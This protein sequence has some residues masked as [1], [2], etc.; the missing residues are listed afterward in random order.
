LWPQRI[1][2][3]AIPQVGEV[4][5]TGATRGEWETE[6]QT[7]R[8]LDLPDLPIIV[9]AVRI[10]VFY[11]LGLFVNVETE[12]PIDRESGLDV[13]RQAPAIFLHEGES[14]TASTPALAEAVGSE[15]THVGRVREDPTVPCG[16]SLWVAFDGLRA[17]GAVNA[18][19][20][21]ECLIAEIES[22]R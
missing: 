2:F 15:A 9:N 12:R 6:R 7:R 19:Q 16:L 14:A 8:L 1:A 11:G 4:L 5:A 18:V 17:A 21:A 10:P 20:I 22:R 3:N 13:L